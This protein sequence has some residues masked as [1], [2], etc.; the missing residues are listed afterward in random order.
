MAKW[1]AN[2]YSILLKRENF[3]S[4]REM[5]ACG[6]EKGMKS[7]L[8][9]VRRKTGFTLPEVMISSIML[10][11]ISSGIFYGIIAAM[12]AQA[13]ASDH[14]RATCIAR[15]RIQHARTMD[16]YSL[17]LAAETYR[18]V[19]DM[20]NTCGTGE[21]GDYRRTTIVTNVQTNCIQVTCQVWFQVKPG[22]FCTQPVQISTM[23][24]DKM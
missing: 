8:K 13:N 12:K 14:Y 17:G 11:I 20:G 1:Y 15:N 16:F 21:T 2:C 19:D 6:A 24:T 4:E 22:V 23:I 5:M 18:M 7:F 10:L 9:L 3:E